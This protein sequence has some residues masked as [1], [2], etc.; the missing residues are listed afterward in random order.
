MAPTYKRDRGFTIKRAFDAPPDV[1][2]QAWTDPK[3]LDW[4]FNP[5]MAVDQPTSVD[6]RVG[7]EWRQQMAIDAKTQYV[8]GGVYHEIV[9]GRKLV[10]T[11]GAR[12]GWPDIDLDT[13]D[14]GPL[15]TVLLNAVPVGRT[16]MIFHLQLPDHISEQRTREWM[17]SG[18]V[19]GW[20]QT[21]NRL[22]AHIRQTVGAAG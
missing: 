20:T 17:A 21:I 2:F 10:F 11:W 13:L 15:A 18:M 9:P 4:F 5:G 16:E 19:E 12:G 22:I 3:F 8:T 14:D 6:L 1:V 7:G